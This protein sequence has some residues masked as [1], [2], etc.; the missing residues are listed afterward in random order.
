[1]LSCSYD[2]DNYAWFF[3]IPSTFSTLQTSRRKRCCSCKMLIQKN[4]SVVKFERYRFFKTDIEERI[5][6]DSEIKIA[7]FYMCESCGDQY[8]NLSALEF[9]I[10]ITE[11]M[12][13]LLKEYQNYKDKR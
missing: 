4:A 3:V 6:G 9:C 5:Y 12:F 10:D 1:M 2:L 13:N 8:F 11:N 7:D